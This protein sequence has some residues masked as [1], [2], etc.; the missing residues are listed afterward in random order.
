MDAPAKKSKFIKGAT[1]DWEVIVGLEVHAQVSSEA[2]LFS[3]ASTEFG[4][5][6][7]SHVSLVDA[8]MP[9]MLPVINAE[10]VRQAVR[11]GLGLNAK[12]NLKSVFDRKNY[13]YPDLPQG[14]QISQYKSPIVG[15]GEVVV[16]LPDGETVRAGIERL[17]LEQDAGKSLHD[18]NPT[19][20]LVDL[21]RAG[22]A[23]MEIVSKPDLRSSEEAKAYVAKLRSVLRYLGTCDGDME[24]GNLR[25]DVNVSVRKPGAPLGTRCEIKNVN[26]IRFIGQAIDYE[27]R[28]QIDIIED[29]GAIEQET[30]LFDPDK[31]ETRSMR[32]KEEAHD[33]RYFPD[34]D[35]LPLEL[36][37]S[38]VAELQ[39]DLPELPDGK[40]VRFIRD[41]AL[42][43]YDTDV[44]VAERD[45]AEYFESVIGEGAPRRDPKLAA[46]WVINELGGRLN[47]EGKDIS[48]APVSAQQLGA[49]LDMI[50]DGTISGKIAKDV[51]EIAWTEGGD[52]RAIVEARGLKQVTDVA[53]IEKVVDEI[54]AKNPDKVADAKTNPKAIGWFVGQVMKASGGKAN[55]QAVNDLLKKKIGI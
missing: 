5:E 3:G 35:L 30:R 4:G 42:S 1:G 10:C 38:L 28:R 22:V 40:K 54:V 6:A 17:H 41:Y 52:P 47:R 45:T 9:G 44:L 13:F 31:G 15:E 8:A 48:A 55:P 27:A 25:A 53:A 29:G 36:S 33:Y 11:T 12:I 50:G 49:I 37:P 46:N 16:D 24:K 7:N 2:K 26:S 32:S 43:A 23:L 34:P 14:Y 21:N 39:K 18:Q 19:M 51:F 20:S